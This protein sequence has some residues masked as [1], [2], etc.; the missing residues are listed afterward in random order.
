MD[1][2]WALQ[3]GWSV[4]NACLYLLL[5][6]FY[7]I[8]ILIVALGYRRQML[9]ERKLF[10]TRMHSWAAETW[11]VVW[12]G[13]LAGMA[14]S[15][16]GMFVSVHLNP[17]SIVC[18]WIATLLLMLIRVRY[19]CLAYSVGLL[20]VVQ[21]FLNIASG[22]QPGGVLGTSVAAIRGLDIPALLVLV[23]VLHVAEALLVRWQ[24]GKAATPLF[25]EGKRGRLVGGYRMEDLWPIPLLLLVPAQGGFVLPWTPLF[26]GDAGTGYMLAALPVL[27]G[28]SSV[29]LG[30]L[31]RQKA[32]L[33]SNRLLLYSVALLLLSLLAAW[34]SPLILLAAL[35]SFLAHEALIWYGN[36]EESRL[37]PMFVHPEQGM[38]VLAVLPDSPA[39]AMGIL[40]G[41]AIYRV[42]G[43]VVN[44]R[45]ELHQ[46]LRINSA[47][48]KLEVRN[49]QGESKFVQRGMY[50]GDHHQLGVVLAP[51]ADAGWAVSIQP[52]S[53]YRIVAMHIGARRRKAGQASKAEGTHLDTMDQ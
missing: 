17:T 35:F 53:I 19:L 39:T 32:V 27:M 6:P 11:R 49:L 12:S 52:A 5:Q 29:T 43:M 2:E 41:E 21:F 16:L 24:G 50:D 38:R 37:S 14:L 18:L 28:F 23:A 47:F 1:L 8:S 4:L 10:H 26:G 34:W 33:T 7:Y 15:V 45:A 40:P 36:I 22:W 25:V 13:L 48:C 46:A 51:D 44:S 31:P 9:L 20:G 30:Q 42:N 3:W